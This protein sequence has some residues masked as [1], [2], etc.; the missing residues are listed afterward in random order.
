[1]TYEQKKIKRI[2]GIIALVIIIPVI[3]IFSYLVSK[4]MYY[5]RMTCDMKPYEQNSFI[6][7]SQYVYLSPYWTDVYDR[8]TGEIVNPGYTVHDYQED[9]YFLVP[10]YSFSRGCFALAGHYGYIYYRDDLKAGAKGV[11]FVYFGFDA[12]GFY[13]ED[14]D[15]AP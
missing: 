14:M 5:Y 3:G 6:S 4:V 10:Y 15:Y 13:I 2:L 1:M 8:E 11:Y 9:Y 7:G 12:N